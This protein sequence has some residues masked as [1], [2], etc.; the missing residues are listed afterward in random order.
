MV[1]SASPTVATEFD[2]KPRKISRRP[3]SAKLSTNR[4]M[5]TLKIQVLPISRNF[6]SMES[7]RAARLFWRRPVG[8]DNREP[9]TAPQGKRTGR[10]RLGGQGSDRTGGRN[11][12]NETPH[13]RK[14][15]N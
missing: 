9:A 5:K 4:P 1:T 11:G 2:R 3:Q 7:S 14:L 10:R 13:R 8:A 12:A 6:V 15:E